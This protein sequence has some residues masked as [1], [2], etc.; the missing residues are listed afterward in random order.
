MTMMSANVFLPRMN[1]CP[2]VVMTAAVGRAL[3]SLYAPVL[4]ENLPENFISLLR[5]LNNGSQAQG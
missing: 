1:K 3:K 2:R 5:C 4:E